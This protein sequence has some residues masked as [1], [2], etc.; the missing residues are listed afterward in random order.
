MKK[1]DLTVA[2]VGATGAVGS[3]MIALLAE[4]DFPVGRLVP[5]A[6]GR[7]LGR[8]VQLR[9]R[10]VPVEVLGPGAFDK[11]DLALFSAGAGVSREWAPQ[12]V[13]AGAVVVDNSS[14][15]RTDLEVPLVVPEVNAEAL[16]GHR[17][18]IANPNCSTIQLVVVL[19]PLLRAV[20]LRR[21]VVAT[22]QAASGAGRRG[23]DELSKTSIELL[24]GRTPS[25][26]VVHPRR[27]AFNCVPQI[28]VF[29]EDGATREEWKMVYETAR[30]L[31][32]DDLGLAVTC[33]RVPVFSGHSEAVFIELA[34][35]LSPELARD[36]LAAAPGVV[37]IDDP[38]AGL[39]PT[40]IEANGADP[41][42]VGRIRRDPSVEHGLSL[43]IV[44]DNLR[45][46]AALNAVQI[47]EE[48]LRQ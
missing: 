44:A 47:A 31:G 2:V 9:G 16:S 33:V 45:K 24:G 30:I 14:A 1:Q 10:S 29:L 6:S 8:D 46:G 19:A 32:R 21:V 15:F 11:V 37:V 18:L 40:T 13:Q 38:A 35:E 34:G 7:S 23:M 27:L 4:R 48:L 3:E 25:E 28:D 43:W 5:L 41:C 39:Y 12:A 26:P 20:G 36:L 42:F 22:Y 17:G